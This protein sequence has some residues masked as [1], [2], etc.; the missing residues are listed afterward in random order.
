MVDQKARRGRLT[1]ESG[2]PGVARNPSATH[3]ALNLDDDRID[4]GVQVLTYVHHER[5]FGFFESC[6]LAFDH[7]R[8]HEMVEPLLHTTLNEVTITL[9]IHEHGIVAFEKL[10]TE[11]GLEC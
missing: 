11:L 1:R 6:K 7:C 4:D 10:R 8:T 3:H 9:E 5:L 2:R